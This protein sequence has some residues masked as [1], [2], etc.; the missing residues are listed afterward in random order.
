MFTTPRSL[1]LLHLQLIKL[2][3][4]S[5]IN[6]FIH[7][8]INLPLDHLLISLASPLISALFFLINRK[9]QR[10]L[11][12]FKFQIISNFLHLNWFQI[13][14]NRLFHKR[15]IFVMVKNKINWKHFQ[16]LLFRLKSPVRYFNVII[17]PLLLFRRNKHRPLKRVRVFLSS[18]MNNDFW[19]IL[20]LI[21]NLGYIFIQQFNLFDEFLFMHGLTIHYR[22]IGILN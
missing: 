20:V 19:F 18:W 12:S 1:N 2:I 8:I 16:T 5:V 14:L 4:N 10:R 17:F 22:L 11:I 7:Q 21:F 15:N 6:N 3:F 9:K 13:I